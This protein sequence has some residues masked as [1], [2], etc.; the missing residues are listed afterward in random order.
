MV[1]MGKWP[2]KNLKLT[3]RIKNKTWINSQIKHQKMSHES[4]HRYDIEIQNT[5]TYILTIINT[6]CGENCE[7]SW[8]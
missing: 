3:T 5:Y 2:L 6:I 4:E 7:T 8:V 1:V